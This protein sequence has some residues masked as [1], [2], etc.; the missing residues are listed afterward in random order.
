MREII[1]L[2]LFVLVLTSAGCSNS[3]TNNNHLK[4]MI[5]SGMNNHDWQNTTPALESIYEES[6]RFDVTTIN[7]G[8]GEKNSKM[9]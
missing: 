9:H 4:V 3:R 6:G 7:R 8:S 5:L 1:C 2:L